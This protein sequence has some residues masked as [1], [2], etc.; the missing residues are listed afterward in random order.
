MN[1]MLKV[2]LIILKL[3]Y[4]LKFMEIK[5]LKTTILLIFQDQIIQIIHMQ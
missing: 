5:K 1:I 3:N 2:I 4:Q